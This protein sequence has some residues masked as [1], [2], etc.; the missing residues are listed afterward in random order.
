ML[1][2]EDVIVSANIDVLLQQLREQPAWSEIPFVI[3]MKGGLQSPASNQVLRALGNVT[4][5]ERPAPMRSVISAV[6]AAV[7]GRQRQYQIRDQIEAIRVARSE[8]E[9]ANRMKD[10]FLAT[11]SHELRT[12][13]NAILGW[14][15]IL[16][17]PDSAEEDLHEG[18][19]IIE[20]NA[21]AQTQLIEELLDMSR[22]VSGTIRLEMNQIILADVISKSIEAIEPLAG[23]KKIQIVDDDGADKV[24]VN[25]DESRMLQVFSNLLTNSVKF[26]PPGGSIHV[27][28]VEVNGNVEVLIKDTGQGIK[29]DFLETFTVSLPMANADESLRALPKASPASVEKRLYANQSDAIRGLQLLVVDDEEDAR[30]LLKRLLEAGGAT[31]R[32]AESAKA[33]IAMYAD[34]LPDVL[35][36]DVGM[37]EV[38]GYELMHLLQSKPGPKSPAIALT[39]FARSEDK[40]RALAAGF[41]A[42]HSKPIE[43]TELIESIATLAGRR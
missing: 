15:Q 7:R 23:A 43:P 24:R 17:Q 27:S 6:Q 9:R 10:E 37:P 4:L 3:L 16:A 36:S 12:P 38:D 33:A 20:R 29:P 14:S 18:L 22:I 11:L 21:R 34:R 2:T 13:L 31:V 30:F 8:A 5:L 1:V 40:A 35:I 25:V 42:H 32:I 26:T 28:A 19:Q 39:A 41:R